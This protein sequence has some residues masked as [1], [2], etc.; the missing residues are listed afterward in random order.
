MKDGNLGHILPLKPPKAP[1]TSDSYI[2]FN[3]S[4]D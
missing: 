3:S 4:S 1:P 2:I